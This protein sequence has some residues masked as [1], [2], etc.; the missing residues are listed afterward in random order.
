MFYKKLKIFTKLYK[1]YY[2]IE[3]AVLNKFNVW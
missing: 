2:K 3:W 1:K